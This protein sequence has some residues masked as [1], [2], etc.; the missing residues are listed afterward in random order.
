MCEACCSSETLHTPYRVPLT[1]ACCWTRLSAGLKSA[2]QP[3]PAQ[4]HGKQVTS[5]AAYER[6]CADNR[7]AKA[8][9]LAARRKQAADRK[10][11][12]LAKQQVKSPAF[13]CPVL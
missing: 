1:A 11:L 13:M 8:D 6:Q 9:A 10:A 5:V 7:Q 3:A 2:C 12:K 4:V